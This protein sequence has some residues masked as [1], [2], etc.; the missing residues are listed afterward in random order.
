MNMKKGFVVF[1]LVVLAG[2]WLNFGLYGQTKKGKKSVVDTMSVTYLKLYTAA[3]LKKFDELTGGLKMIV[4]FFS[5][6]LRRAADALNRWDQENG[7]DHESVFLRG[8][9]ER[10][11]GNYVR[12]DSLFSTI[13][14]EPAPYSTFGFENVW[15][16]L[17]HIYQKQGNYEK[18]IEAYK[19][20]VLADITDT[21]P[22]IRIALAYME[23]NKPEEASEAFYAGLND[24]RLEKNIL[25]L[26]MDVRDIA[27][28]EEVAWWDT[29]KRREDKLE[30]LR[31]F[32]KRRDPNPT[33]IINERLIEH[34]RRLEYAQAHF[35]RSRPPYYDDRGMVYIRWGKPDVR[36]IGKPRQ[37]I[38]ENET[39][40]YDKIQSGLTIDFVNMGAEFEIR[41]LLD[42][43][44]NS[45]KMQD[46]IEMFEERSMHHP[47]YMTIA[48]KIRTQ[49]D[50]EISRIKDELRETPWGTGT[51]N[52]YQ[53]LLDHATRWLQTNE[54]RQDDLGGYSF[55]GRQFFEFDAG[56]PHL[57]INFNVAT[58]K[59][60]KNLSRLEYYYVVPFNQM[61][62]TPSISH[63]DKHYSN[64][65][66]ILKLYDLK[67]NE[68][69]SIERNYS[70]TAT[71]GEKES[72]Y[73]LDQIL[74][75]SLTPGKYNLALEI[76]N[77]EKDRVGIY[78]FAVS[79][80]DYSADTLTLSHI[81]IA[82]YVEPTL[83]RDKYVKPKSN[84]MVVP[85]PAAGIVKNKPLWIYY[86]IY[87]LTL[88]NEGKSAYQISY[89][90]RMAEGQQSF[91]STVA[92][93]FSSRRQSGTSTVT[94]KQG[95]SVNEKEY[96]AFDISELPTGIATLEVRVKDLNSGFET[97][98][99]IN[100][101][102]IEPEKK[103]EEKKK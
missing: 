67:Y 51:V 89:S 16:Q 6:N 49:R 65:N 25:R 76:R 75:D 55:S 61:V 103:F 50:A 18:A 5:D 13:K 27:T 78:Q 73:F 26:F 8:I 35:T 84:L 46:I 82:Q 95:K 87:N 38:K 12:A 31:V 91:I 71:T 53:G 57:P 41:S 88:N 47:A 22:L 42:A 24:I 43:A 21:W 69:R 77:N 62:F 3:E 23:L 102:I 74:I 39:W 80:R 97:T 33:N 59:S 15:I 64:L 85:N 94:E 96:I 19:Q 48:A 58:F 66:L 11:D 99:A 14:N 70:V 101:T 86:E 100:I 10:L 68:L 1:F 60:T 56:A 30:F 81:E 98:S 72:H 90:I 40:V 83:S 17:G 2:L 29:L 52:T 9:L 32:W 7:P 20:G 45:A 4:K 28:K 79:V 63:P 36:Y 92:G 93:L 37:S 44:D 34:Y 54:Y